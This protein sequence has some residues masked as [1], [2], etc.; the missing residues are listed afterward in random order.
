MK[1]IFS[2]ILIIAAMVVTS[3]CGSAVKV[4][5]GKGTGYSINEQV[6]QDK[7]Y[8]A[9]M[10]DE[11]Y[12][13]VTETD[14]S[15]TSVVVDVNGKPVETTTIKKSVSTKK[16]FTDVNKKV[17]VSRKDGG[18]RADVTVHAKYEKD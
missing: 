4:G 6:A 5:Q 2:V 13:A 18:Y 17:S 3:S 12:G 1:K 15:I 16:R 14:G 8:A 11:S 9:A 7:A 10:V